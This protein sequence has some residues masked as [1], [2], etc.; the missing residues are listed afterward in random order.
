MKIF[1][2]SIEVKSPVLET[3]AWQPN[4]IS[5]ARFIQENRDKEFKK[6]I[7]K[8]TKSEFIAHMSINLKAGNAGHAGASVKT[9]EKKG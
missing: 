6:H 9:E 4:I 3:S 5:H 2:I 7:F 1:Y 8:Y